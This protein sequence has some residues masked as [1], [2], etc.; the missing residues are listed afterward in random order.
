MKESEI[1]EL[2][3]RYIYKKQTGKNAP[4]YFTW[5]GDFANSN[6]IDTVDDFLD[7]LN[8]EADKKKSLISEKDYTKVFNYFYPN[9]K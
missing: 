6:A 4:I 3:I 2:F 8:K 5:L 1:I 7:W 9:G